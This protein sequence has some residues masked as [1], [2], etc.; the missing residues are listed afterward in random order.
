MQKMKRRFPKQETCL[1]VMIIFS[2]V[3]TSIAQGKYRG[4]PEGVYCA[5]FKLEPF[6]YLNITRISLEL[7]HSDSQCGFACLKSAS[8]FSYNLAAVPDVNGEL[9]CE[10]L[11]SDKYNNSA[12]FIPSPSYH[13]LSISSPCSSNPCMNGA[14]CTAKYRDDDYEC[15]CSTVFMGK[16]CEIAPGVDCEDMQKRVD[17]LKDGMY[18]LDPDGGSHSNAFQAYCDMTSYSGGWTMCYTTDEYVTPKT[19]VTYDAQ[20]PYGS[21]GY[22]TNCNNIPFTEIIFIDHQNEAKAY[23]TRRNQ[24]VLTAAVNYGSGAASYGLWDGV[25]T[26]SEYSYQLLICHGPYFFGFMISGYT[27]NSYKVCSDWVFDNQSPYFRSAST[28]PSFGGVA[29]NVNGYGTL[30]KKLISV[31]LR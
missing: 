21:D 28:N 9:F 3:K 22:R 23:F 6:S 7:V 26:S 8:C 4:C 25:G 17:S 20:F 1:R 18:W 15:I 29:F 12:K 2:L 10:L 19:E 31:G 13:H 24:G 11:P 16:H 30:T 14:T 5:N 27:G